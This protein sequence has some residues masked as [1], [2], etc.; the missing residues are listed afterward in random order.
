MQ[1]SE[2]SY[3]FNSSERAL[4]VEVYFPKRA[5]YYG[6]IFDSLREGYNED[7]VK[8]YL[9]ENV[10][11]LINEFVAFPDL[12]KPDRYISIS[13]KLPSVNEALKRIDMYKSPF[14]GWSTYSVDGVFFDNNGNPIEEAT[15]V[16]RIMFRF[17]SSFTKQSIEEGCFDVLRAI[18]FWVISQHGR[19]YENK[20]WGKEEKARFIERHKP[21][22]KRKMSFV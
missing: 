11:E 15:Q 3:F 20:S 1:K 10:K 12:L 21:W 6:A 4:F 5:A 9:R 18:L 8:G 13:R 14:N 17:E 2:K 19:L 22:P 16:V 7:V